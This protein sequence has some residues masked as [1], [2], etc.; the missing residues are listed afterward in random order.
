MSETPQVQNSTG[1]IPSSDKTEDTLTKVKVNEENMDEPSLFPDRPGERD[2]HYFMRTGKCGYGSSCRYNHPVSHVPEAVFYHREE[3]PER[4]GQPDCEYFLKTGACKYGAACKYN[5]PKDRNGAGPVL[6]N[7]LGYP[8]RQGE[9]SCPYYMQKGMCRFGVAC[10]FHHPQTH[11]AQPTSFPFGGSLPVMSLAPATYEAMSRPQAL[12]PQAYSFM[13][14]PP[15]GWSTFMVCLYIYGGYDMK[16]E[17][18]SSSEKAECSFFM[19]TGTCKYG[20]NCKYSHPKERMLLSPPPN[21]FNPVVLPARPGLPACG[22]FK[23]Y[24]FCKYGANCKFDH[25]VPVNTY[26]NTGSTM[27]SPPSAYAPPVSTPVRITSPPSG[28]NGGDKPAAED[29][30]S[31]TVKEE[32][33]PDKAEVHDSSQLSRSGSTALSNDAENPGPETKK[34]DDDPLPADNS[35]K[36]ESSDNSA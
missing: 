21:L 2:C 31:E 4:V 22:N 27:P 26:N 17:L 1:S 11:N 8:M 32:D 29:N 20:D 6:F 30:S 5:H 10:K 13:V 24:G 19:K 16:T 25:P 33:G 14:A 3:L 15:Q 23:A 18:D 9:K 7:A 36:Q 28:S 12:H 34:E 35:G